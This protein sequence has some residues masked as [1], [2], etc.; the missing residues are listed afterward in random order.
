MKIDIMRKQIRFGVLALLCCFAFS[1]KE[2]VKSQ[3]AAKQPNIV[4]IYVDDLG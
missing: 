2:E 4:I 1:C 3:Q